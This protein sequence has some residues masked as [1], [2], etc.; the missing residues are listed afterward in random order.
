MA[1]SNW[2]AFEP[3]GGINGALRRMSVLAAACAGS[4][5]SGAAITSGR[6]WRS[7]RVPERTPAG[8]GA[9]EVDR[10]REPLHGTDTDYSVLRHQNASRERGGIGQRGPANPI[11]ERVTICKGTQQVN[12][13]ILGER[14]DDDLSNQLL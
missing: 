4:G 3:Y 6:T 8:R 5:R 9:D 10:R 1:T 2:A 11:A 12:E 14:C 13:P 7:K